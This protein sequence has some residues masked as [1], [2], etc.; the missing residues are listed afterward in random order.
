MM[1]NPSAFPVNSANLGGPGAYEPDPG[2][3]LRDWF[4]GQALVGLMS[5]PNAENSPLFGEATHF[6]V[7][8]YMAADAM[9]TER[10]KAIAAATGEVLS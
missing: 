10:T 7:D 4:A 2:M 9:L 5:H 3:T 1:D 8:A 6:A